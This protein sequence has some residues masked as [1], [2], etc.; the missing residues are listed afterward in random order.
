MMTFRIF[1]V[2]ALH[3]TFC[4][5]LVSAQKNTP[6]SYPDRIVLNPGGNAHKSIA[7]TCCTD[8]SVPESF[9]LRKNSKEKKKFIEKNNNI[10]K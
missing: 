4:V 6:T 9:I 8:T 3:L 10:V 1:C 2:L 5:N 7:I